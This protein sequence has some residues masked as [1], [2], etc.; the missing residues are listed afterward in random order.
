M[1]TLC[2]HNLPANKTFESPGNKMLLVLLSDAHIE[3]KGFK[4]QFKKVNFQNIFHLSLLVPDN[5]LF[6]VMW[7]KN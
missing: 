7:N 2:N 6:I 3:K 5:L 1:E 4:A